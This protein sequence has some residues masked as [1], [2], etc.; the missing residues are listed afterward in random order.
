MPNRPTL[1]IVI[2]CYN[3]PH[4]VTAV[5]SAVR[6]SWPKKEII[7][8]D[9]GSNEE[10]RKII[11]SVK[12]KIDI[13]LTQKNSGQSVARNNGIKK[14]AG[15]YILNLDSDDYFEPEFAA[16]AIKQ[17]EEDNLIRIVTCKARRFNDK[18]IIDLYTPQ[19]GALHDFLFL[20]AA[21]GSAMFKRDDW[22]LTGGYEENLPILGFEDWE[23]YIQLL[24]NGGCAFVIPEVLFNYRVRQNSTT[25]QIKHLKQEKFKQIILK[26]RDLYKDNFEALMQ[27]LFNRLENKE[28]EKSKILN[29][30]E[31]K[32]GNLLLK[33]FRFIKALI[34]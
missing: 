4:V 1:S 15:K 17:F 34:R 29:S 3:D 21:L 30:I 8:I 6:Q 31:Q 2:S 33:P 27:D 12:N 24:K 7:V 26:H 9:D 11:S 23:F 28:R 22:E 19:G 20:N 10:T 16:K 13:L 18:G 32:T 25:A 5:D 14:A